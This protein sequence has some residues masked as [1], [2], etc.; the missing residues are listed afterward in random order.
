MRLRTKNRRFVKLIFCFV[1][2]AIGSVEI[3]KMLD[4]LLA[5]VFSMVYDV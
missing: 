4:I 5:S 3:A 2:S 1:G